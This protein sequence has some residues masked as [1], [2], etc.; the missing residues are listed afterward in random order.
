MTKHT[1]KERVDYLI[2][3]LPHPSIMENPE[4]PF[5]NYVINHYEQIFQSLTEQQTLIEQLEQKMQFRPMPDSREENLFV[6]HNT[7]ESPQWICW[8]ESPPPS[9]WSHIDIDDLLKIAL[10]LWLIILSFAGLALGWFLIGK[11]I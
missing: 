8:R 9:M 2:A 5:I 7:Q 10:V 4:R 1:L 11:M 6:S 3:R